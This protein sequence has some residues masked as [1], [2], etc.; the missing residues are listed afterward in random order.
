IGAKLSGETDVTVMPCRHPSC[1]HEITQ[2]VDA[3]R[4]IDCRKCSVL[5]SCESIFVSLFPDSELQIIY[6]QSTCLLGDLIHDLGDRPGRVG[7]VSST[8]RRVPT[9]AATC[10]A[11]AVVTYPSH[12]EAP[13]NLP[14][15]TAFTHVCIWSR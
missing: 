8:G 4:R 3:T 13:A 1:L 9:T 10:S 6:N 5:R 7:S 2:T 15:S 11:M 12:A 14:A